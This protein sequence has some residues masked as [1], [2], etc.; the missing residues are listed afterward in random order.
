MAEFIVGMMAG[1]SLTCL[2]VGVWLEHGRSHTPRPLPK[3][4]ERR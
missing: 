4:S 3:Y 2:L 1:A